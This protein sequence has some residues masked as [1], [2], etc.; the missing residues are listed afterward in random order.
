MESV[1]DN[2][3]SKISDR[4]RSGSPKNLN[5]SSNLKTDEN[6]LSQ[7]EI[8]LK[9]SSYRKEKEKDLNDKKA[10]LSA[11]EKD[12]QTKISEEYDEEE[13]K[14]LEEQLEAEKTKNKEKISEWEK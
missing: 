9:V 1:P 2:D 12:L 13:R 5:N 7:K 11:N 10:G 6:K 4:D 8:K 3:T 14:K